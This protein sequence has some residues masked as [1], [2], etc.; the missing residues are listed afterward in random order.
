M[1]L[2]P[3]AAAKKVRVSRALVSRALK[4]GSLKG[5]LKNNGHWSISEDD[6]D[7][8]ASTLTIRSID[9]K[10]ADAPPTDKIAELEARLKQAQDERLADREALGAACATI[11]IMRSSLEDLKA[12]RDAWRA[13]SERLSELSKRKRVGLF[14]FLF[15]N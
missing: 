9:E 1:P 4:D 10:P 6:L 5:T 8:W 14:S 2:T 12:D 11:E 3:A 15:R 7:V 13:Q